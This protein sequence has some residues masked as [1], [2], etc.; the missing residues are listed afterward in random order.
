MTFTDQAVFHAILAASATY[1]TAFLSQ[2]PGHSSSLIA[3]DKDKRAFFHKAKACRLMNERLQSKEDAVSDAS[4]S[5]VFTLM[6][7]EVSKLARF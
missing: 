6:G 3:Q 1:S 7:C 4:I 2:R 5:A